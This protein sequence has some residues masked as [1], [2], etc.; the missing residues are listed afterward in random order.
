MSE[1]QPTPS[2]ESNQ[3]LPPT[4]TTTT[5]TAAAAAA[6]A[7]PTFVDLQ[8]AQEPPAATNGIEKRQKL[9]PVSPRPVHVANPPVLNNQMEL[10]F[11]FTAAPATATTTTTTTTTTTASTPTPATADAHPS[12]P[13]A[14]PPAHATGSLSVNQSPINTASLE[15]L[16]QQHQLQQQLQQQQQHQQQQQQHH[17]HQ[18]HLNQQLQSAASPVAQQSP[19]P[20]HQQ[21]SQAE[22][23]PLAMSLENAPYLPLDNPSAPAPPHSLS[24]SSFNH[25]GNGDVPIGNA[26]VAPSSSE[27]SNGVL[28]VASNTANA[29]TP[30]GTPNPPPTLA[31]NL[32]SN[33]DLQALLTKLSPS[34]PT[35]P[36]PLLLSTSQSPS[37]SNGAAAAAA[38]AAAAAI[39]S[40]TPPA[41]GS[42]PLSPIQ[43]LHNR[44]Q[45]NTPLPHPSHPSHPQPPPAASLPQPPNHPL[46]PVPVVSSSVPGHPAAGYPASLPPPPN[47]SHHKQPPPAASVTED[48][49]EEDVRP[50]TVDEEE[51]FSRFLADER[52]YVTQGQWDRF[53]PGSRL[54]IG[55]HP[56]QRSIL[57]PFL[58]SP[59]SYSSSHPHPPTP[60]PQTYAAF[61]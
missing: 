24:S 12:P 19:Q 54:F 31:N 28:T 58:S 59:T 38:V 32:P 35:V 27:L 26:S 13:S 36:P 15:S 25:M 34:T 8:L 56:I 43:R 4:T 50:F 39:A 20:Q 9:S 52:D 17:H 37:Q 57:N 6:A 14:P 41:H 48:D 49:D 61:D 53:P 55:A 33:V 11:S 30:S 60:D 44:T 46:P 7:V 51:E 16:I 40:S 18:H 29:A 5:T 2:P 42:A 22:S 23:S 45:S 3:A 21:P 10:D 47:F 1:N